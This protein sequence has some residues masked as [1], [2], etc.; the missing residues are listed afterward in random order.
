MNM[1]T[2]NIAETQPQ[3][4]ELSAA[5]VQQVAGG[6]AWFPIVMAVS[7]FALSRSKH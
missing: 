4:Q 7:R 2:K 5:E 3:I 6:I 1:S